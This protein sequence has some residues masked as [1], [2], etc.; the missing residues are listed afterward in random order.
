M[1]KGCAPEGAGTF[2]GAFRAAFSERGCRAVSE[3]KKLGRPRIAVDMEARIPAVLKT[4]K[5]SVRTSAAR[6]GI[7]PSTVQRISRPFDASTAA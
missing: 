6:F 2:A 5:D 7:D 1:Q 4:R 3:G